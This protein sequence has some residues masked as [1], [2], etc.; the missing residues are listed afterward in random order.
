MDDKR[1]INKM[2]N[3]SFTPLF[4]SNTCWYILL[5]IITFIEMALSLYSAKN[6]KQALAIHFIISGQMFCFEALIM[7]FLKSYDYYP[8]I[9]PSS[10]IE[11]NLFA[12]A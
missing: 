11:D 7:R 1:L 4:W 12:S 9:F 10:R 8:G 2:R 5:G 6:R 3:A